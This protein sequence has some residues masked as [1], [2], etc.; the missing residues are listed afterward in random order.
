M[1]ILE[2]KKIDA[3]ESTFTMVVDEK[4]AKAG[5]DPLNKLID[6]SPDDNVI[7]VE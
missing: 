5:I 2:R 1:L 7:S 3:A 6:R 4:P